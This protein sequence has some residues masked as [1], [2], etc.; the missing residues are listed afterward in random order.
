M[1]EA[2]GTNTKP[3]ISLEDNQGLPGDGPEYEG[4]TVY[5]SKDGS[6]S[7]GDSEYEG[8]PE[9]TEGHGPFPAGDRNITL[10]VRD[11]EFEA[12]GYILRKFDKLDAMIQRKPDCSNLT[13]DI[14]GCSA[15]DFLN[16]FKI[17]YASVIDGPSKFDVE[18][19]TSALCTA[20]EYGYPALRDFAIKG[21]EEASLGAAERLSL[22]CRFNLASR[23]GPAYKELCERDEPITQEEA[24]I[25]E[26]STFTNLAEARE[27]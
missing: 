17:L 13:L 21:L 10:R 19:L 9:C 15:K 22:A 6:V 25:L 11:S 4:A 16:T 23:E 24:D 7:K 26:L 27:K 1:I 14:H 12:H 3:P 20:T 2:P 18:T 8:E 5:E